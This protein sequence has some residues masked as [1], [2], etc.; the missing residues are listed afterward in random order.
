MNWEDHG[1]RVRVDFQ[2]RNSIGAGLQASHLFS[3]SPFSCQMKDINL[4][5]SQIIIT[6]RAV[7]ILQTETQRA[8]LLLFCMSI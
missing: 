3:A 6:H 2:A 8:F 1:F 5:E 7:T 4:L